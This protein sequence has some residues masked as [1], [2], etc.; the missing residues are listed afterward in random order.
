MAEFLNIDGFQVQQHQ[1]ELNFILSKAKGKNNYMEIGVFGGGTFNTVSKYVNGKHI[2]VDLSL[3]D[4]VQSKLKKSVKDCTIIIG[5]T[6]SYNTLNKVKEALD[7]ELLEVLFIDGDHSA[8]GV[9]RDFEMYK[10]F[11]AEGGVILF[12]DIIKSEFHAKRKCFVDKFWNNAPGEKSQVCVSKEWG[13]VGCIE[14][15]KVN[16]KCF[17]I[18][19]D[20]VSKKGLRPIFETYFNKDKE[21]FFFENKVI[22]DIYGKLDKIDTDYVG[23]CSWKF[24]DKIRL[25]TKL[26]TELVESTN[27]NYDVILF[28][29][30]KFI[31]E[32]CIQRNKTFYSPIYQIC[33]I[34]DKENI[35]PFKTTKDLWTCSYCNYWI[36]KK[37][38]Y[39]DYCEKVLIPAMKAFKENKLIITEEIFTIKY[40]ASGLR[41]SSSHWQSLLLKVLSV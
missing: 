12:H 22:A 28:P 31:H 4:E 11:V 8:E 7:G 24:S 14:N 9:T 25:D 23:T 38:V 17:Q 41:P 36:A 26:F 2:A 32:N 30:G 20:K 21:F 27:N 10:Q 6:H 19:F 35:L 39:K 13:G 37:E 40:S 34:F 1:E 15:T 33:E 18:Y 5:D 29:P 16:W 3:T